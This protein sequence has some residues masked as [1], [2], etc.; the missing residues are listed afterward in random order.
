MTEN[1]KKAMKQRIGRARED[2]KGRLGSYFIRNRARSGSHCEMILI[3]VGRMSWNRARIETGRQRRVMKV[4]QVRITMTAVKMKRGGY[5]WEL[6]LEAE[7][8][9]SWWMGYAGSGRRH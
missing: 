7:K 8:R 9:T 2:D 1:R 4:V 6:I 3:V 5:I